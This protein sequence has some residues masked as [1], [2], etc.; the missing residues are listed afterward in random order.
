MLQVDFIVGINSDKIRQL[1][2][3]YCKDKPKMLHKAVQLDDKPTK[4]VK[5]TSY[6]DVLKEIDLIKPSALQNELIKK[7]EGRNELMS[8]MTQTEKRTLEKVYI[9]DCFFFFWNR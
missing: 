4:K 8:L 2:W 9:F 6:A 1:N 3:Q 7:S 5:T